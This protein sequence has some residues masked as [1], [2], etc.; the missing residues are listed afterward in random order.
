P[1]AP[2]RGG[3]HRMKVRRIQLKH[4]HGRTSVLGSA[5]L[6]LFALCLALVTLPD[7]ALALKPI[8]VDPDQD[9]IEVTTLGEFYDGRGDSLQGEPAPAADG[10]P[11][12]ISVRAKTP[13]T[14]PNWLVFALSNPT[15]KPIERWLTA[16]RY[17]VIGSGAVWPDLDAQRIEAVTP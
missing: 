5:C 12:R 16:E 14:N 15:D 4:A 3:A 17:N 6:A 2:S 13:G 10:M 11:G 7:R 9:R 8:V 1:R